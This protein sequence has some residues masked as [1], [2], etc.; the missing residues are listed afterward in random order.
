M[1]VSVIVTLRHGA[2]YLPEALDSLK[3]QS[4]RDFEVLVVDDGAS[5][6]TTDTIEKFCAADL[7]FRAL[8]LRCGSHA[9]C[10]NAGLRASVGKYITFLDA[11]DLYSK[12]YLSHMVDTAEKFAA[13]LTIGR[14]R[15]FDA[16]G[17][18][19]FSSTDAL[20]LRKLTNRFDTSLIWNPAVSNKL[21][22]REHIEELELRFEELSSAQ[23]ALF[24]LS[25]ALSCTQIASSARGFLEFRNQPFQAARGGE[26]TLHSYLYAYAQVHECAREAFAQAIAEAST[27]FSRQELGAERDIY[28][29]EV[30][31]KALTVILY[32]FYR[33]CY[34]YDGTVI[35]AAAETLNLVF[36][37]LSAAGKATFLRGNADVYREGLLPGSR[38]ELL[39]RP[40]VSV[41]LCGPR[42]PEELRE[43][44]DSL[45]GQ[46]L[47]CFELLVDDSL[48]ALFPVGVEAPVRPQTK[49]FNDLRDVEDAVPYGQ[50][51]FLQADTPAAFKQAALRESR[52]P[53]ILFL[54]EPCLLD[55]KF[56]QRHYNALRRDKSAGFTASPL[57]QYDG[58]RFSEYRSAS[59]AFFQNKNTTRSKDSPF[60]AL[61]LLLCNKLFR[62]AHL[63]GIKFSFSENSILDVYRVYSNSAFRKLQFTGIYLP[64]PESALIA[65]MRAQEKLLPPEYAACYRGLRHR[66][67]RGVQLGKQLD[68][69]RKLLKLAKRFVLEWLNYVFQWVF[70]KLPLKNQLLFFTIRSQGKLEGNTKCLYDALPGKKKLLAY[71]LPHP[72]RLKPKL[73]Y[74]LMTSN[75]IITDDYIPYLRNFRLR[76]QQ[77]LFQVW[78]SCGAFQRFALD[79][80]LPH[81]RLEELKTHSQYSAAAVSS[82]DCRQYYAHAFGIDE[83][84]VLPLG[85]PYTDA[86]L[87]PENREFL[88]RA[89]LKNHPILRNKKVYLFCPTV[90]DTGGKYVPYDPQIDWKALNAALEPDEMLIIHRHPLMRENCLRGKHYLHLRDYSGDSIAELLAVCDLLI[91]DY[92]SVF[93][94]ACLLDIPTVFYCPDLQDFASSFYL[95][96]P[97]DLPGPAVR[98]A[99]ALL[100]TIRRTAEEPPLERMSLFRAAQLGACDGKAT[101]RAFALIQNWMNEVY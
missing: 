19:V 83:R 33:R 45:F 24:T 79:A 54:D 40:R 15:G 35:Q 31:L 1:K 47:P 87:D 93:Y 53:Y 62:V 11:K 89:A 14:M 25:Y 2:Q 55:S 38:E 82:E 67:W 64:L 74:H 78:H 91:T 85:T 34:A 81:T 98:E 84:L 43:Q 100:K 22:L 12:Q 27:P 95:C 97:E 99:E 73:Y 70:R 3:K 68:Q 65:R 8:S 41:A 37:R 9:A 16:F 51:R 7:R 57:S 21:F 10:R 26:E 90:R 59:L 60:F 5:A 52:S 20:S 36:D 6:A 66:Y 80:P 92:S 13:P 88:R 96:Y 94:D 76:E 18:H 56:L 28:L 4:L 49:F 44:L 32:R 61:D 17:T 46:T 58:Q 71:L 63:N 50:L 69:G 75:I 29:D 86:L 101:E 39:A 72:L 42:R 48:S 30:Y 23:E 77:R